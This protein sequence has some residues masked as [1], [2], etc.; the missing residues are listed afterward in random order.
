LKDAKN[1]PLVFFEEA[2]NCILNWNNDLIS[3]TQN[4]KIKVA[5]NLKHKCLIAVIYS[6]GLRRNE[7]INLK[8]ED[9]D[10]KRM[11]IKIRGAKGKKDRCVQLYPSILDMFRSY[12]NMEKPVT[13]LFE[14]RSGKKYS[15]ESISQVIK[16][17]A[18][19]A[20]INKRVYPHILC[21]P[22]LYKIQTFGFSSAQL[23]NPQSGTRHRY[24]IY[25]EMVGT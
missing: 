23:C 9:I 14:G 1:I 3:Q 5:T 17:A 10:S 24:K 15:A 11:L 6:C 2:V 19:K 20:N 22:N 8:L 16:R 4:S 18:R 7:I 25:P 13:W 21:Y 12:Y